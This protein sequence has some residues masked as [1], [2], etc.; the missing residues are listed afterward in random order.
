MARTIEPRLIPNLLIRGA[1]VIDPSQS[2]DCHADILIEKGNITRIGSN[3]DASPSFELIEAPELVLSPGWCD[4]HVHFREPGREDEET[5]ATGCAAAVAGGFTAACPMPNTSP[6]MDHREIVEAVIEK[7]RDQLVEVHPIAAAT[8]GR[9]GK[10]LSEMAELVEAGAVA[11]SDDGCSIATAELARRAMEYANM[12]D[13]PIIEHAEDPTLDD[14]GAM[15]EGM[16]STRLGLPGMPTVAE[17]IMVA[18]DILLADYTGAR[19]HIA[20]L[21]SARS[22]ELIRWAKQRGIRVTCEVTPH[23]FTLTEEAVAT[24][25]YNAN[26][27][28][29]PPLRSQQDVEAMIAGLQ[30]GTIDVIVTD[31]AP[32]SLEE[33]EVEFPAAPFGIIGLETALGLIITRLV[34]RNLLSLA[35]AISKVTISP[36]RILNLPSVQI[37]EGQPANLL[38]FSPTKTW[39]VNKTKFYSKSRNTPFDGWELTGKVFAVYNKGRMW[40]NP[41]FA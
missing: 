24:S 33:K 8:K 7:A 6:A 20:H 28:M 1:R 2:L 38:L 32:H 29:N 3:L 26:T 16:F 41:D 13:V 18:R 11:F 15:N 17:D 9:E 34:K 5:I 39:R 23:H 40:L 19:V 35:E 30:D 27:K 31:H 37:K 21:S 22:L 10:E 25:G 4:M 36:R 14:R 12:L